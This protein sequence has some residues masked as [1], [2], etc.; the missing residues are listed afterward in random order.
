MYVYVYVYTHTHTSKRNKQPSPLNFFPSN[1]NS[2]PWDL[3][4]CPLPLLT[5]A[6]PGTSVGGRAW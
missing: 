2:P 6:M 1:T 4:W 3:T 5:L